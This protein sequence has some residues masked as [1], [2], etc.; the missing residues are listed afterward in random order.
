MSKGG[1]SF[2]ALNYLA[3]E[4]SVLNTLLGTC[5]AV[6]LLGKFCHIPSV[7]FGSPVLGNDP[8]V[9]RFLHC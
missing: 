8:V 7:N 5:I 6:G 4:V 2:A 1:K 3:E 9:L